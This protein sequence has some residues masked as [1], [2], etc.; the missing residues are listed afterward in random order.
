MDND[1]LAKQV[2]ANSLEAQ[3]AAADAAIKSL[4]TGDQQHNTAQLGQQSSTNKGSQSKLLKRR[5][6]ARPRS[7]LLTFLLHN[8]EHKDGREQREQDRKVLGTQPV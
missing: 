6:L 2:A 5:K 4:D 7:K 1:Y 3:A 8:V